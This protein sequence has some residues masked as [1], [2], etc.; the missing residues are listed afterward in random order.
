MT[1]KQ[2]LLILGLSQLAIEA[3]VDLVDLDEEITPEEMA[4]RRAA[5]DAAE[6]AF[7]NAKPGGA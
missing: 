3:V 1:I 6:N 5:M 4:T 2:W 7:D